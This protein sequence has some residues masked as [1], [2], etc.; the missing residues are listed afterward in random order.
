MRM[1]KK[2]RKSKDVEVFESE[3]GSKKK[4]N[5]KPGAYLAI[6]CFGKRNANN[7]SNW[8]H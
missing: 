2:S 3:S 8:S 1:N 7:Y 6:L 4:H 5:G